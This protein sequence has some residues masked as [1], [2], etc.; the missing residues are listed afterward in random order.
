MDQA[1]DICMADWPFAFCGHLL[2]GHGGHHPTQAFDEVFTA[3][4]H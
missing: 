4:C 3:G 1:V 2:S